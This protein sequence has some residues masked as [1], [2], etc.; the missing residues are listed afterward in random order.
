[1][2]VQAGHIGAFTRKAVQLSSTGKSFTGKSFDVGLSLANWWN[3]QF[4]TGL[5]M[6]IDTGATAKQGLI[7]DGLPEKDEEG[8]GYSSG[9]WK[10]LNRLPLVFIW[11]YCL[12]HMKLEE[13][14]FYVRY[15]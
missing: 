11:V 8:S 14:R 4:R 5:R 2:I 15:V 10:R 12:F 9:G 3:R 1:M 13:N 6:M 7:V